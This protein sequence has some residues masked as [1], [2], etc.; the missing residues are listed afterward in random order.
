MKL[1][2]GDE[3]VPVYDRMVTDTLRIE[4]NQLLELTTRFKEDDFRGDIDFSVEVDT[5]WDG[6]NEGG[7]EVVIL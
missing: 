2:A 3:T 5:D 6:S 7:G 4:R 1:Y